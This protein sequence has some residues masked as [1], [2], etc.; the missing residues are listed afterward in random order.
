MQVKLSQIEGLLPEK[1][2]Q[3]YNVHTDRYENVEFNQA[4]DLIAPKRLEV[5]ISGYDLIKLIRNTQLTDKSRNTN[6]SWNLTNSQAQAIGQAILQHA[7]QDK[8]LVTIKCVEKS[9]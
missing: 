3:P 8:D 1:K 2:E 6:R 4:I 7:K 9:E 5:V